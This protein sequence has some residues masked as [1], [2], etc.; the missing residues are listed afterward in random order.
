MTTIADKSLIGPEGRVFVDSHAWHDTATAVSYDTSFNTEEDHPINHTDTKLTHIDR[1][2]SITMESR[3][4]L[5]DT[6]ARAV[7]NAWGDR[8]I[9]RCVTISPAGLRVGDHAEVHV[10]TPTGRNM[11]LS[12]DS[13]VNS[14]LQC[15]SRGF[16]VHGTITSTTLS[17]E[18]YVFPT[19]VGA[20]GLT[21]HTYTG[22][23]DNPTVEIF[24]RPAIPAGADDAVWFI[25]FRAVSGL[26]TLTGDNSYRVVYFQ[27]PGTQ[28]EALSDYV[29]FTTGYQ[30]QI[31]V[32]NGVPA[33][34]YNK[35]GL[36]LQLGTLPGGTTNYNVA[37]GISVGLI[38]A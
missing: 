11:S 1:T 33:S 20:N 5:G 27:D 26:D 38:Q 15:E 12:R 24:A 37:L 32:V 9:S 35:I 18:T 3:H 19:A 4:V 31:V 17:S 16:S 2:V 6:V 22:T 14:T 10:V 36:Q 25:A 30:R 7:M 21:A 34:S 28:R 29:T 8:D 23:D 13:L